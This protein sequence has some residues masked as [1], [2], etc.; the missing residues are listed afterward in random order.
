MFYIVYLTRTQ[1]T[2]LKT[3]LRNVWIMGADMTLKS[4]KDQ[5]TQLKEL[6]AM[7]DVTMVLVSSVDMWQYMQVAKNIMTSPCAITPVLYDKL[8]I[9]LK[10]SQASV[11]LI[12]E[13]RLELVDLFN[14]AR[15][16]S[17]DQIKDLYTGKTGLVN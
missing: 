17:E 12:E 2:A 1:I 7:N 16:L 9:A 10:I 14:S 5:P 11:P 8:N 13:H 3:I 6:T 4:G 15:Y